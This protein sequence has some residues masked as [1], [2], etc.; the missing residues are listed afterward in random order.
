MERRSKA[1]LALV[2]LN[3]ALLASLCFN[4]IF[5]SKADAQFAARP[6]EYLMITGEVN[7]GTSGVLFCV[8][9]R[10]HLLTAL[11]FDGKKLEAMPPIDLDRMLKN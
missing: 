3:V 10:N 7:G 4:N 8:D 1:I 6:S 5:T 2:L 11:N 9:T